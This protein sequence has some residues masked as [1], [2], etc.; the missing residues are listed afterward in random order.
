MNWHEQNAD[1]RPEA[2]RYGFGQVVVVRFLF[3]PRALTASCTT[4]RE[5]LLHTT[6]WCRWKGGGSAIAVIEVKVRNSGIL[7]RWTGY[8]SLTGAWSGG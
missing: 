3:W 4:L 2:T 1:D 7:L 6:W 8:E 5:I